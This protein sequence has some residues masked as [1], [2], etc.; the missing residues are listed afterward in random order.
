MTSPNTEPA[1]RLLSGRNMNTAIPAR[2]HPQAKHA[3]AGLTQ[4]ARFAVTL[5]RLRELCAGVEAGGGPLSS[6]PA[7][8]R[9][10]DELVRGLGEHV[11]KTERYL[12]AIAAARRDLLPAVVDLR[13]DHAALTQALVD[14]RLVAVNQERWGELPLRVRRLVAKVDSH[15]DAEATLLDL[16]A[17]GETAVM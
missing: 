3:F 11:A 10:V 2:V 15:R 12:Q 16:A 17:T 5:E 9:L 13:A 7:P 8:R 1:R 14:L 4:H 6:S